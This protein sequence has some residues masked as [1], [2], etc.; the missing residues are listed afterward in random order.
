MDNLHKTIKLLSLAALTMLVFFLIFC[1]FWEVN[2]NY[3]VFDYR[4]NRVIS[5]KKNISTKLENMK[6][7]FFGDMMLDR[8]VGIRINENGFDYLFS[9][10]AGEGNEFFEGFDLVGCN[11]EGAVTNNGEHYPPQMSYDFAFH[12]DLINQLH[13]YN[14]NFF[15]VA[16]NHF[17]DQGERGIIETRE[18][19]DKLGFDYVGC[20]DG[21]V[22][23]CS[24]EIIKIHDKKIGM[25]GFSQVYSLIDIKKAKDLVSSLAS[26]TD[27][28]IVNIHW[29]VEYE[30]QFNSIQQKYAHAMI[31]SGADIIIGH[32]P[33]VVQGL[34]IYNN[35]P[36]FYSLGN[37]IFDQYFSSDTQKSLAVGISVTK[38]E[39]RFDLFPLKSHMSQASLMSGEEKK[40]F[41][42]KFINWSEVNVMISNQVR[43]GKLILN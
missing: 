30:H 24:S 15:T 37:F 3:F 2:K 27:L 31:D 40:E 26:S 5:E 17:S 36:I 28:V 18:N 19:L 41:L 8:S 21:R 25:A 29:G 7:L 43:G 16:N 10:L 42:D 13:D 14:F 34:E 23:D 35:K 32:H 4:D 39:W 33:H 6:M 9:E 1:L 20:R 22:G 12:P 38:D 11:L